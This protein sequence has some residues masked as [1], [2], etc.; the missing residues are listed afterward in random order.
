M[1]GRSMLPSPDAGDGRTTIAIPRPEIL[2][3]PV[4]KITVQTLKSGRLFG[5]VEHRAPNRDPISALPSKDPE[6]P[7][8]CPIAFAGPL[9][10]HLV[11]E[12]GYSC[13]IDDICLM[14]G[15]AV[16]VNRCVAAKVYKTCDHSVS[17]LQSAREAR[18]DER[19][20]CMEQRSKFL[21]WA[22]EDSPSGTV[23]NNADG[24]VFQF[25]LKR[26]TPPRSAVDDCSVARPVIHLLA[27]TRR[28]TRKTH[29]GN[30]DLI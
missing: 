1:T 30:T 3:R 29:G 25:R 26:G 28:E 21:R 20:I 14:I 5:D 7:S 16:L 6:I 4:Q 11:G 18:E 9:V 2:F 13:I 8:S 23:I 10:D 22:W 24:L 19:N 15:L 17:A 27:L 12:A